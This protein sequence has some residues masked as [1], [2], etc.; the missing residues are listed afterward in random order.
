MFGLKNMMI[1]KPNITKNLQSWLKKLCEFCPCDLNE[2]QNN[3][4]S[5]H[6]SFRSFRVSVQELGDVGHD[7][8]LIRTLNVNIFWIDETSYAKVNFSYI[9]SRVQSGQVRLLDHRVNISDAWK[10]EMIDDL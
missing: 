1:L 2:Q 4:I 5:S 10:I 3:F 8:L 7:G 9:E 6:L